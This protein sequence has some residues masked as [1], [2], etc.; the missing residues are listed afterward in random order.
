MRKQA[1]S[2]RHDLKIRMPQTEFILKP[3]LLASGPELARV[4]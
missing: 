4:R 2:F 1:V 3:T